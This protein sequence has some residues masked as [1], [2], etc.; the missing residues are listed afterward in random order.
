MQ[1]L[2]ILLINV[3]KEINKYFKS[4]KSNKYFKIV[5]EVFKFN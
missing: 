1:M 5:I 2:N 3:K 4:N